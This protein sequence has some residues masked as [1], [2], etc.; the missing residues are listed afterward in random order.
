LLNKYLREPSIG[1]YTFYGL[2]DSAPVE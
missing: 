1:A 2:D